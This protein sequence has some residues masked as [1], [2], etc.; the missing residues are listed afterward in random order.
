MHKLCHFHL[1]LNFNPRSPRGERPVP[2]PPLQRCVKF[3]S[4]LSARRATPQAQRATRCLLHFNPRSPRGERLSFVAIDSSVF[5]FQSTLS[6][7][8]ATQ[9]LGSSGSYSNISIHALREESDACTFSVMLCSFRFQST[10]SARRA[11]C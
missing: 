6:A 5:V 11:T 7:R 9:F 1:F 10:L 8:R 4:T 3:Q 2:L